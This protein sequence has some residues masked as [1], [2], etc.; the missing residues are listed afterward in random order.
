MLFR[1]QPGWARNL[2][3]KSEG[4]AKFFYEFR[5][6]AECLFE[7]LGDKEWARKVY[8]KAAGKAVYT[9]EFNCLATSVRKNL[10]EGGNRSLF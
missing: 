5:R 2:Y 8:K 1:S 6:L 3:V 9:S 10:G 7:N 4:E